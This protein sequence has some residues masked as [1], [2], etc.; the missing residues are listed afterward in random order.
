[1]LATIGGITVHA[2]AVA[3]AAYFLVKDGDSDMP[4]DSKIDE[5]SE[6]SNLSTNDNAASSK[7]SNEVY[8][9]GGKLDEAAH[10]KR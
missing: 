3:A 1:M 9:T 6:R 8:Q 4:C 2:V 7:M 5:R 10:E